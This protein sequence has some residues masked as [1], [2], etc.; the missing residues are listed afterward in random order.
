MIQ[1]QPIRHLAIRDNMNVIGPGRVLFNTAQWI[2]E[3]IEI[4][5]AIV[6]H[7]IIIERLQLEIGV[8]GQGDQEIGI[9]AIYPCVDEIN[10]LVIGIGARGSKWA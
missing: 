5:V 6:R 2:L 4:G 10:W 3:L 8:L 9:G 7:A 1:I